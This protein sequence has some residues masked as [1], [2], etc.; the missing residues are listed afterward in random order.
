[1]KGP[2]GGEVPYRVAIREAG[3]WVVAYFAPPEGMDGAI[4]LGRIRR[5]VLSEC[6]GAWD[7]WRSFW[8]VVVVDLLPESLRG[9]ARAEERTPPEASA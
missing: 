6:P 1:M 4:E 8:G 3:E 9:G 2:G 5:S 7:R